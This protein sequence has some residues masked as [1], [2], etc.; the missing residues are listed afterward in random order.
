MDYENVITSIEAPAYKQQLIKKY[1]GTTDIIA[2][3]I[4]CFK[5]YNYQAIPV[6]KQFKTGNIKTDSKQIYDFIKKNIAYNAEP[7][8]NQTTSSFS[9]IIHDKKGDCKH[10]ALIVS[11]IGYNMGY[12]VIFRFASYDKDKQLGHVYTILQDPNT[13]EKIIV[14]PLQEFNY[15]KPYTNKKDYLVVNSNPKQMTLSRLSGTT[16]APATLKHFN[17]H[18]HHHLMFTPVLP[19]AKIKLLADHHKVSVGSLK[20]LLAKK[21]AQIKAA[22]TH[23][24][25]QTKAIE[26]KAAADVKA[27][28]TKA[29]A[30]VKTAAA[31]VKHDAQNVAN[32][33]Q[34]AAKTVTVKKILLAPVR[35]ALDVLLLMN[36]NG[37]ATKLKA[38][39]V[40]H[41]DQ[42][43]NYALTFG[44][45]Y[46]TF[47]NTVTKG[48]VNKAILGTNKN[49]HI[50]IVV[51]STMI[52]AASAAIVALV[53]FLKSIGVSNPTDTTV[54]AAATTAVN[55]LP[56]A[57]PDG[58]A[59][60][61]NKAVIAPS[62]MN[63]LQN[64]LTQLGNSF[65]PTPATPSTST[66]PLI[67]TFEANKT[68]ILI[69]AGVL[70]LA[71]LYF[72]NKKYHWIKL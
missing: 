27:V 34:A 46:T 20:S 64:S 19:D 53:P 15:E 42:T 2:D 5:L 6:A 13:K 72:A 50:G 4:Y 68:P 52:A 37:W 51:T 43:K 58:S 59:V 8:N 45:D 24:V 62:A 33:V 49:G 26:T 21:A 7:F 32:A 66:T 1:Q 29:A 9:R 67:S 48:A 12:N 70:T 3:L 11:D 31:V 63:D 40:S 14:D 36:F 55:S 30:D 56:A 35:G 10:S 61:P 69:G 57:N 41:P 38:A 54:A 17:P 60:D 39:S 71:G 28:Q 44:Y 25:A 22:A 65:L 18:G 16:P 47:I 23:V